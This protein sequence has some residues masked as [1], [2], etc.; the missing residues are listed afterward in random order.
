MM[1]GRKKNGIEQ[2][3][4]ER[5]LSLFTLAGEMSGLLAGNPSQMNAGPVS[6]LIH[7]L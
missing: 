3:L 7:M 1:S 2:G 5:D 6:F 4:L